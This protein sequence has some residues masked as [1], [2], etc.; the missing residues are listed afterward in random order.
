MLGIMMIF[1]F[2]GWSMQAVGKTAQQV[3]WEVRRQFREK[4]GIMDGSQMPDHNA[5]VSIVTKAALKEMIKPSALALGAP[6]FIGFLFR[7]IG[8]YTG[9]HS[10]LSAAHTAPQDA[11]CSALRWSRAFS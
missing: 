10:F 6:V 1:V 4:P 8:E 11:E 2:V 5:C 7:F 3:V 9:P